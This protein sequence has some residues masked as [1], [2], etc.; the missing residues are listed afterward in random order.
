MQYF[1]Q[2]AGETC[3]QHDHIFINSKGWRSKIYALGWCIALQLS[4]YYGV[5]MERSESPLSPFH[6]ML[7]VITM[8]LNVISF[9]PWVYTLCGRM[10]FTA[11]VGGIIEGAGSAEICLPLSTV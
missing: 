11:Q 7:R 4:Q 1:V 2:L 5:P 3:H 9:I 6:H 10:D 8:V